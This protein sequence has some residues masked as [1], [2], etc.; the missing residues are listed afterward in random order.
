MEESIYPINFFEVQERS[1]KMTENYISRKAIKERI[2]KEIVNYD[3]KIQNIM[4]ENNILNKVILVLTE[5]SNTAR[6]IAKTHFEKIITEA[7]QYVT[8]STDY[9]FVIKEMT[10]R[11]KASYEFFIKTT[12]NGQESLQNPKDANGGGFVDIISVAAKY[13]YLELFNDPKIQCGTVFLDEPGKMIDE[14]RSVKFAE[15]I[16]ELGNNY[17]RQTIMITHN[18]NLKDIA[19]QTH[20]VYQDNNLTSK[21]QQIQ[22]VSLEGIET[23]VKEQ[24]C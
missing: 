7:L 22:N 8:Q 4:D 10:D 14:Q 11:S 19:D 2:E 20:Y 21:V 3:K 1:V 6:R 18:A 17:N 23:M 9:E 24:L 16:K 15:Y 5:S 13:A 12:V